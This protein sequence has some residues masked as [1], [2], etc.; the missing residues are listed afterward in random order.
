MLR[1]RTTM[2]A[3]PAVVALLGAGAASQA[4]AQTVVTAPVQATVVMTP[5]VPVQM[6]P[7]TTVVVAPTAPPAPLTETVPTAPATATVTTYWQPGH[8]N[9]TGATW[10]WVDGT[11]MQRVQQP[12]VNAVWVQGQWAVQ[13]DGSYVWVAAHWQS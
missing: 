3:V 12:T 4:T 2:L 6:T 9:W 11:Y 1:Q 7:A 5:T 10:Q 8:W 13:T